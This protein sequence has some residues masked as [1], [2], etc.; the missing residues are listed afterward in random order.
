MVGIGNGLM[1]GY[2]MLR[3]G[4]MPRGL[5]WLGIIGGPLQSLAG[6]GVLFDLYDAGRGIQGILTI[7]EIIWEFL[8]WHLPAGL[9]NKV[10]SYPLGGG[11]TMLILPCSP[12]E[13]NWRRAAPL[14][15]SGE[16]FR[17]DQRRA[18]ERRS[19]GL[20]HR[21]RRMDYPV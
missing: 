6:I 15:S 10:L 3:S 9:G 20:A 5:C 17:L 19:G 14:S 8:A 2:L 12:V 21:H 4:L 7:P 11:A 16:P 18:P 1:L 13:L